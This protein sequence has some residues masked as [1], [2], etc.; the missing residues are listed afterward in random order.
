MAVKVHVKNFQSL[1][2]TGLEIKGFTA[3]T[4]PNNSGKTALMRAIR[5]VFQNAPGTSF[6]SHGATEMEVSLSFS[7]GRSI[8]WSKGTTARSKP[9]YIIDGGKPIH[10]GRGVPDEVREFNVNPIKVM[11]N[12]VWPTLAPQFT[13]QVFLLDQPGS[14]LAEAVADVDRVSKLNGALRSTDKDLRA[15]SSKLKVRREDRVSLIEDLQT[16]DGLE[17]VDATVLAIEMDIEKA[18]KLERALG[19]MQDYRSRLANAQEDVTRLAPIEEVRLPDAG[20][21]VAV[22]SKL[23]DLKLLQPKLHRSRQA[24]ED[25]E[26]VASIEVPVVNAAEMSAMLTERDALRALQRSRATAED[27]VESL[28]GIE[29]VEVAALDTDKAR[30]TADALAFLR[31]ARVNLKAARRLVADLESEWESFSSE[32][33]KVATEV[34]AL[35]AECGVCP[36]CGSETGHSH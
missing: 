11:G 1:K 10:P 24:V 18:G 25:L 26:S 34:D 8:I 29:A 23:D 5:G 9:T 22:Q 3:V 36:T 12:E 17:A 7:D 13:G 2:N 35:L 32:S 31:E 21:A 14:A 19:T 15:T 28:A 20:E 16:F 30:K 27:V 4:G 6:I 33:E